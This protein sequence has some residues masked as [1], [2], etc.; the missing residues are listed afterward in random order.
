MKPNLLFKV[1][2]DLKEC[3]P[4]MVNNIIKEPKKKKTS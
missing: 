4:N 3:M 1:V 2:T